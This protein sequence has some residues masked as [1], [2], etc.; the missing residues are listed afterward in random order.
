[1]FF[2]KPYFGLPYFGGP[3]FGVSGKAK[4]GGTTFLQRQMRAQKEAHERAMMQEKEIMEII[5]IIGAL[6]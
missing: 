1:M 4:T 5:E 2:G 6:N 3:Y